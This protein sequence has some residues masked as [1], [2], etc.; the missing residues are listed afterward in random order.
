MLCY[1]RFMATKTYLIAWGGSPEAVRAG[2]GSEKSAA[3][4]AFGCYEPTRMTIMH[5]TSPTMQS[6]T[7][8]T[9]FIAKVLLPEHARRMAALRDSRAEV[10][11]RKEITAIEKMWQSEWDRYDRHYGKKRSE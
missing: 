11:T 3:E 8:R 2:S 5:V 4:E 9:R 7:K 1:D 6:D 10:N